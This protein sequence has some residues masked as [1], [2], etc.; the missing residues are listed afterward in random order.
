MRYGRVR[1]VR[2][3]SRCWGPLIALAAS[4]VGVAVDVPSALPPRAKVVLAPK[5][6]PPAADPQGNLLGRRVRRQG[7]AQ[8]VLVLAAL[9]LALISTVVGAADRS[10]VLRAEFQR[11]HPCASTGFARGACPGYQVDHREALVCGGRDELP[12]LQ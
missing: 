6:P 7:S 2:E 3:L 5:R 10:R 4:K 9:S 1:G 11:H 12:N 8:L